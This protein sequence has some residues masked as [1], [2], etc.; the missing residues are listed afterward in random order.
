MA[1]RPAPHVG[2]E[3]PIRVSVGYPWSRER[4]AA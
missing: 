4:F 3:Q 2:T 1:S